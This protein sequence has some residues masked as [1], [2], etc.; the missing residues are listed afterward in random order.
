VI[1]TSVFCKYAAYY[2]SIESEARAVVQGGVVDSI[3]NNLSVKIFNAFKHERRVVGVLQEDEI[4]KYKY[5][6]CF[7]EKSKIGLSILNTIGVVSLFY[8]SVMLWK[9]S[10]ISIGNLTYIITSVLN[11]LSVLWYV[12]DELTYVF[13]EVGVCHRSLEIMRDPFHIDAKTKADS[14]KITGGV[15]KFHDVFFRYPDSDAIFQC[16]NLVIPK[17][18]TVGLVGFSGSG[19]TTFIRLLLR[20]F[21]LDRGGISVDDQDISKINLHSLHDA[22]A[23]IQQDPILFHRSVKDNIKYGNFKAT[24]AEVVEAA[25]QANCMDF[26][27]KIPGQFDAIVGETGTKLSGGQRQ[28]IVIARAILKNSK[29]LIM[30]EATSALDSDTETE[31]RR[32]MEFLMQEKTVIIVAHRLST[33]KTVDRLLVFHEGKIV[34]D[35]NHNELL[36]HKGYYAKLWNMQNLGVIS[37]H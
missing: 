16:D 23:L 18:Q 4:T 31:I 34:E 7:V 30:D 36:R 29:I 37:H 13:K 11:V 5:S 9:Q 33:L 3:R 8:L 22:I 6:L 35:G 1:F 12:S 14:L 15:I 10:I 32:S 19:K 26:I 21:C 17:N 27:M 24:D 25:K 2:S 28:R 20:L